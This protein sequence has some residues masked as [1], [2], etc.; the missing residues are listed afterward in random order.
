MFEAEVALLQ[1]H[2]DAVRVIEVTNDAIEAART[3]FDSAALALTTIWSRSGRRLV[4]DAAT[5]FGPDIVHFDNTF[6]LVSPGAYGAARKHGAAVVQTLHNYRL[7]CP[8]ATLYRD[9]AVCEDCLGKMPLPGVVHG[10]Y[11]RSR[12]Q[13]AVVASMLAAHRL[14]RTWSRDVDRYIALS[15]FARSKFVEGGLPGPLIAVK[16]NFVTIEPEPGGTERSEFLFVGR[17][18]PEKGVRTLLAAALQ[19]SDIHLRVAGDGPLAAEVKSA[20]DTNPGLTALGRLNPAQVR[21]EMRTSRAL[22]FPSE[23]YEG[24]PLA[25]LEAFAC[26]MPVIAS[27][28]GAMVDIVNDSHTGLLFAPGDAEDL[29]V[30]VRWAHE[31]PDEMRVMGDNARRE[32]ELKYTPDRNYSLLMGIYNEALA[33]ARRR[34]RQDSVLFG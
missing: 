12:P 32:Y 27:R 20:G 34:T 7:V 15:D 9:G 1:D 18:A 16:P 2:G 13:S 23:W 30:K 19:T 5:E 26:G 8:A 14:R 21:R 29:A 11:R 17:L 28:L 6:P 3:P 22:V 31:H 24:F 4:A 10:C 33:H 25:I